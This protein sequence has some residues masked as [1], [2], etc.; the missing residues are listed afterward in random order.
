MHEI[1]AENIQPGSKSLI[2]LVP[3]SF[4]PG[5]IFFK[6][7]SL[8]RISPPLLSVPKEEDQRELIF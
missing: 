6:N 2:W 7:K 5:N 4:D 3:Q 1:T 8:P